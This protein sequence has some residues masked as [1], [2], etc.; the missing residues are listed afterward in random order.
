MQFA[1]VQ[2]QAC[3]FKD[4][5]SVLK[6]ISVEN[7]G[8][9]ELRE[10]KMSSP[11]EIK[12]M[13]KEVMKEQQIHLLEAAA[14]TTDLMITD[15]LKKDEE[16]RRRESLS[17]KHAGNQKQL[18]HENKIMEIW[19]KTEHL[20]EKNSIKEAKDM[21][22]EGKKL[23]QSRIKL[24]RLADREGWA[25]ANAY[26]SDDLASDTEDEKRIQRAVRTVAASTK[27]KIKNKKPYAKSEEKPQQATKGKTQ[28][29][30][31]FLLF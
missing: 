15:R 10:V 1:H 7:S 30:A 27:A 17:L 25:V 9:K 24:I 11:E 2:K 6:I 5:R 14:S 3:L 29:E 19:K 4:G 22:T 23:T 28:V 21:I 16:T 26:I 8:R 18:S 20:L 12:N 31:V 13:I